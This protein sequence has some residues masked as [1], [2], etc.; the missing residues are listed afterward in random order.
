MSDDA[1]TE[2]AEQTRTTSSDLPLS[3]DAV[4]P[5]RIF[6]PWMDYI[7]RQRDSDSGFDRIVGYIA[8]VALETLVYGFTSSFAFALIL[9]VDNFTPLNPL[10]ISVWVAY[11]TL[12]LTLIPLQLKIAWDTWARSN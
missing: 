4:H 7:D 2:S 8:Q 10:L 3:R 1:R 5:R 6:D 12:L 11:P 9:F